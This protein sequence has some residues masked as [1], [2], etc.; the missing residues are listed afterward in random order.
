MIKLKD[1]KVRRDE[2]CLCLR[3][4]DLLVLL[5]LLFGLFLSL[6]LCVCF[7]LRHFDD[8]R[9][10][11][12]RRRERRER[13]RKRISIR[14]FFLR[15]ISKVRR[16]HRTIIIGY[17]LISLP[18]LIFHSVW[19]HISSS[20]SS[21]SI[22]F[23][24]LRLRLVDEPNAFLSCCLSW[25]WRPRL[26]K[27]CLC[28]FYPSLMLIFDERTIL[29][30][31]HLRWKTN[32]LMFPMVK[33]TE[34]FDH[35]TTINNA[36]TL[37]FRK[38]NQ[39]IIF[40]FFLCR[41][42]RRF[43]FIFVECWQINRRRKHDTMT[44]DWWSCQ[45][46]NDLFCLFVSVSVSVSD[47]KEEKEERK[48]RMNKRHSSWSRFHS[49]MTNNQWRDSSARIAPIR[50]W[51][52]QRKGRRRRNNRGWLSSVSNERTYSRNEQEIIFIII[53][54]I[55][56]IDPFFF[57]HLSCVVVRCRSIGQR[58]FAVFLFSFTF[59]WPLTLILSFH[60]VHWSNRTNR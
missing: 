4:F 22:F 51:H 53:Q 1:V 52:I 41:F 20:S 38:L 35:R 24:R 28:L 31:N 23:L 13:Q 37:R 36:K 11:S 12:G 46:D 5:M 16:R 26:M 39:K 34:R 14:V 6:S 29:K 40:V 17:Q 49:L 58:T 59:V 54:W 7:S 45:S 48:Q 33:R 10:R 55:N 56:T 32:C 3:R 25:W 43:G 9:H 8:V 30:C 44:I 47:L 15:L 21:S 19:L 18:P 50:F 27:R 42:K 60:Y 2:I 57:R